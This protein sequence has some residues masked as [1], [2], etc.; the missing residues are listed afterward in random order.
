MWYG[1]SRDDAYGAV[2]QWSAIMRDIFDEGLAEDLFDMMEPSMF[3]ALCASKRASVKHRVLEYTAARGDET[4]R[5]DTK[6]VDIC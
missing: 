6:F 3:E 4:N 5:D 1:D 2:K